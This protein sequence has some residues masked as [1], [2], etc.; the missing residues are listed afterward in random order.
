MKKVLFVAALLMGATSLTFAQ[1]KAVKEAKKIANGTNPDFAKAEGLINQALTNPE[2]KD[3]AETWDVAGFIQRRRS[4]EEM[5]NAYLRKPYDTLQVYNSALNMCRYYLKC[6]ELAQIPNEKGKIKNKY[7]KGNS[8]TMLNERGNLINGGIQFYN[9]YLGSEK[10]ED[11][12][13][14]LDFFGMYVDLASN[15]MFEDK[16]LEGSRLFRHVRGLGVQPD[17]RGQKLAPDR[18]HPAYHRLLRQH[19]GYPSGR[20]SQR[21]EIRS[22]CA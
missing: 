14:A 8:A 7:R 12:Q 15:P 9:T 11:G 18:H 3:L 6:D 19:G 13:K 2:T 5:K 16:N 22:L 21:A 1:E 20:L 10:K 4:E 17:V